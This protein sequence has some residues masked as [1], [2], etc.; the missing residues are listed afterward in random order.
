LLLVL[1]ILVALLAGGGVALYL[2]LSNTRGTG[3]VRFSRA[4]LF[5][6]EGG[7]Q[8]TR[9]V[10]ITGYND[11][12]NILGG[13]YPAWYAADMDCDGTA[14]TAGKLAGDL[15]DG[16]SC[17]DWEV[18]I[19]DNHDE[20]AGAPT[21]PDPTRDNDLHIFVQSTCLMFADQP[22]QLAELVSYDIGGENNA[23]SGGGAQGSGNRQ[24][25]R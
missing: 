8:T 1:V 20:F 22:R 25:V 10:I 14:E 19:F 21:V 13:T 23:S 9:Q 18:T 11:W 2:Q 3:L 6:A 12:N 5:C 7:L 4:A 17:P 16:G 24:G 15:G